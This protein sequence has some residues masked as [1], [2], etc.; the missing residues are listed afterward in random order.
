MIQC[1]YFIIFLSFNYFNI[2]TNNITCRDI[3]LEE[4]NLLMIIDKYWEFWESKNFLIDN[5]EKFIRIVN[6]FIIYN[7]RFFT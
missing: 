7:E 5:I 1:I 2:I 4:K 3:I 6:R